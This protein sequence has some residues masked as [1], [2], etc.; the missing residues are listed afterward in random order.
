MNSLALDK[1]NQLSN[2]WA[3]KL[4]G[5]TKSAKKR[6]KRKKKGLNSFFP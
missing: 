1:L 5:R 4:D 6:K 3:K 2:K